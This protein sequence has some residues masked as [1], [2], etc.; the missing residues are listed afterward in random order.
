MFRGWNRNISVMKHILKRGAEMTPSMRCT[1]QSPEEFEVWK[2]QF[3][4]KLDELMGQWPQRVPP[5]PQ[6]IARIEREDDYVEKF[7][8]DVEHDLSAPGY[9]LLP[10]DMKKGE[11]RPA[12][13]VCHGHCPGAKEGPAGFVEQHHKE[14]DEYARLMTARG[15]I[16]MIIDSRGFGESTLPIETHDEETRCNYLYLLYAMLGYQL[17]T[18]NIHDQLQTLDYLLSR[19]EVDT[20]RVGVLG[21]SFGGTK[22]QYVGVCDDRIKATAICGYLCTT[23]QYTFEDINNN[24]GSQFVP[25]LYQYGDVATVAGLI[26]PRPLLIQSGFVDEWFPIETSTEAHK[27]LRSIYNAAG[28]SD[29]LSI[30]VFAGFHDFNPASAYE[31]FDKWIGPAG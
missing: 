22:A 6:T 27:E 28:A 15:Y 17:L 10:K 21:R 26:A 11:K 23:L 25:G 9:L 29:R 12:I 5:N 20:D 1:A 8:I 4:T 18:L 14:T 30:D 3:R 13:L 31:F 19:P 2:K 16:T 24:C 7:I